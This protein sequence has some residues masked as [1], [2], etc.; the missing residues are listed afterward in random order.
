MR[1]GS[2]EAMIRGPSCLQGAERPAEEGAPMDVPH[3]G[4]CA[5]INSSN[6]ILTV[7]R[8]CQ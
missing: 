5:A 7:K 4:M 2:S 6:I 3:V 8:S 1:E